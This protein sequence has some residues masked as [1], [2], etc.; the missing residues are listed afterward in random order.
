VGGNNPL[1]GIKKAH[2]RAYGFLGFLGGMYTF[3]ERADLL[4]R[5]KNTFSLRDLVD[6]KSEGP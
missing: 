4:E 5:I 6:R 3:C 1:L 2:V